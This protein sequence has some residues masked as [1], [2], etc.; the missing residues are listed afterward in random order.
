MDLWFELLGA[1]WW[2]APTAIGAGAAG[3][4]V[5]TSGR[6]R[7]RRLELDAARHEMS[8]AYTALMSARADMRTARAALQTA[9]ANPGAPGTSSVSIA[10]DELQRA[11]HA[12]RVAWMTLRAK[13]TGVKAARAQMRAVPASSRNDDSRLPLARLMARHDI[14]TARW[15]QY[16]T[17]AA[18]ALAIPQMTDARHPVT[19]EF[20]AAEHH[21]RSLRPADARAKITPE[22]F[23]AYREAVAAAE[24][25]FR[26]AEQDAWRTARRQGPP[27]VEPPGT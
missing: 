2:V 13:R 16:E 10:R 17:D 5:A 15:M 21:A 26:I 6:R 1:W 8:R 9:K 23:V 25:A 24:S 14:L 4:G 3:Y 12:H 18:R 20:V 22:E 7:A 27:P 19:A 11:K